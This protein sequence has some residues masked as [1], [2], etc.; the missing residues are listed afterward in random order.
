MEDMC[1]PVPDKYKQAEYLLFSQF[2][3][4]SKS[5]VKAEV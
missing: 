1:K 5:I 2:A 4:G 3:R